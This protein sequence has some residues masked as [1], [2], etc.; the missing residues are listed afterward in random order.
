[1]RPAEVAVE[2]CVDTAEGVRAAR[3][4]GADRVELC[5]D[6]WCG[7]L[8]PPRD[9]IEASVPLAPT[10]GIQVLIRSR[11]GSFVYT[12]SEVDDMCRD[13]EEIGLLPCV[14]LGF[15]VGALTEDRQ[16]DEAAAARFRAAAGDRPL[17]FHR[18][19]DQ[20]ADGPWAL[21]RL[22]RLGYQRVLTT[23]GNSG[24]ADRA[25]LAELVRRARGRIVV[26]ASGGL[27]SANVADVVWTSGVSEVH[28][29]APL[30][31][32]NP[33]GTDADEVSR[34]IRAVRETA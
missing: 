28:M 1:M 29:R 24:V 23:G 33:E 15:V 13:I 27:R 12:R 9:L 30:T 3:E 2:I 34:I 32:G 31:D 19:F 11:S 8:T 20:A 5:R 6:L 21:D 18:A 16:I 7:G 25:G 22:V 17:T 10:G 26:L 14:A 4:R